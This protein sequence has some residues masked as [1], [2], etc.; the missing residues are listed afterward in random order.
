M[1]PDDNHKIHNI[2]TAMKK[3]MGATRKSM[4]F[5]LDCV[6]ALENEIQDL[7]HETMS[8]SKVINHLTSRMENLKQNAI[9]A[10]G[11]L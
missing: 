5:L 7:R 2:K 4:F 9:D 10:M 1:T 3:G 6:A 8:Q 11:E